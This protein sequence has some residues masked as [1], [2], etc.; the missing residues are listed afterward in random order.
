M[1]YF[2][3]SNGALLSFSPER[4]FQGAQK[5]N[6][7][8][9]IC[10]TAR[11]NVVTAH[12]ILQNGEIMESQLMTPVLDNS[13]STAITL[14]GR[15]VNVWEC[16]VPSS[17]TQQKGLV[18]VV[19]SVISALGEKL[20]TCKTYFTVEEGEQL[21]QPEKTDSYEQVLSFL[22][23]LQTQIANGVIECKDY[24]DQKVAG[25]ATPA[26]VENGIAECKSYADQVVYDKVTTDQ[27]E[28]AKQSLQDDINKTVRELS[29][30][31]HITE[32]T[33]V[34]TVSEIEDRFVQRQTANGLNV[35][36]GTNSKLKLIKGDTVR[37]KN[38][39][40]NSGISKVAGGITFSTFGNYVKLNG[41]TWTDGNRNPLKTV[42]LY[43]TEGTYTLS[44][45]LVSGGM[46]NE[47]GELFKGVYCSISPN[48]QAL[49]TLPWEIGQTKFATFTLSEPTMVSTINLI[50]YTKNFTCNDMVIAIQLERGNCVTEF[51][52]YF[53]DLKNAYF[54]KFISESEQSEDEISLSSPIMLGKYDKVFPELSRVERYTKTVTLNGTESFSVYEY[55]FHNHYVLPLPAMAV[56]KDNA[57][58]CN[59]TCQRNE[60]GNM[61][62]AGLTGGTTSYGSFY[63]AVNRERYPA[64]DTLDKF[65]AWLKDQ[66]DMGT[67]VVFAYQTNKVDLVESL[68]FNKSYALAYANG[69][70]RVEQGE[71]DNGQFGALNTL[72]QEYFTK[73]GGDK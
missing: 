31:Y 52:P 15:A 58:V 11:Q 5:V 7:V 3:D 30:L 39:F 68:S 70:E 54:H 48:D 13:L 36:D 23:S 56:A 49:F 50:S 55:E 66:H 16:T 40:D 67:P 47:N 9:F 45:K 41:S 64:I 27:L 21:S 32:Q 10:P 60:D 19:F 71:N 43:L 46:T 35:I 12:F 61:F 2:F 59:K 51:Q 37:C 18:S 53:T 63:I 38:F 29:Q 26:Q 42:N 73:T 28:G 33:G 62:F 1:I 24:T 25:R 20:V 34:Y 65:K 14:E 22:A 69:H 8:Y 72:T 57:V 4:V 17:V 44:A 6:C